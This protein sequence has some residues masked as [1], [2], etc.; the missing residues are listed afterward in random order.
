MGFLCLVNCTYHL[1]F[2][3]SNDKAF[4]QTSYR[5]SLHLV[6]NTHPKGHSIL[7]Q[8]PRWKVMVSG[9]ISSLANFA[10][11]SAVNSSGSVLSIPSFWGWKIPPLTCYIGFRVRVR[12]EALN[13]GENWPEA[14]ARPQMERLSFAKLRAV[15]G[16]LWVCYSVMHSSLILPHCAWRPMI[17]W[18][19]DHQHFA[20]VL[21]QR[22]KVPFPTVL[23]IFF[24]FFLIKPELDLLVTQYLII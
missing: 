9:S 15:C 22:K 13:S 11:S 19:S 18:R 2:Y 16:L 20:H 21:L 12:L 5:I 23:Y 1:K 10:I 7:G 3:N 8:L 14:S 24:P 6:V 17:K 4:N